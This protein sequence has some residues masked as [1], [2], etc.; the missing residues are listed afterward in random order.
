MVGLHNTF[1]AH[2]GSIQLLSP[3]GGLPYG[4][5]AKTHVDYTLN[6]LP[7]V[8]LLPIAS[9]F[10]RENKVKIGVS[11]WRIM[12]DQ[13]LNHPKFIENYEFVP[14]CDTALFKRTF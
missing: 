10:V 11:H 9:K 8:L 4:L 2:N 12:I 5:D 13:F 1:I 7:D 14:T 6:R 3:K